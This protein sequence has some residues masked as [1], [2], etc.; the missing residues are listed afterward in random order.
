MLRSTRK[1]PTSQ[2]SGIQ[3]FKMETK[4][5]AREDF[6][7]RMLT[8]GIFVAVFILGMLLTS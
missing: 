7:N 4:T 2:V 1:K 8:L 6:E 3:V 5:Q